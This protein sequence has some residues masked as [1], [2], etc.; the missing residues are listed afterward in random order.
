MSFLEIES[1]QKDYPDFSLEMGLS[2]EQGEIVVILGPSGG[3]KTTFL[4]IIAGLIAPDRGRIFLEGKDI[5]GLPP[6]QRGVGMVFQDFALFPHYDV[7]GNIAYGPKAHYPRSE[8][9][10]LAAQVE[11]LLERFSLPG[12]GP[13]RIQGLS[14]G[15]RQRVALARALAIN[16]GLMLFDEPLGSLDATLRK[17]L[18]GELRMLQREMGYTSISVTHDQEDALAVADRIVVV[19]DGRVVQTGTPEEVYAR[20][21]TAFVATFFGDANLIPMPD[22]LRFIRAEQIALASENPSTANLSLDIT[23]SDIE[24]RG[25]DYLVKGQSNLG[26]DPL[27]LCFRMAHRPRVGD[28]VRIAFPESSLLPIMDDREI[29]KGV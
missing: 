25:R 22:G 21:K 15:E 5:T 24:Y 13:R 23:V 12:F 19:R 2:C 11:K 29:I 7:A 28:S 9:K 27:Q 16:P 3:G 26:K 20:P 18:R 14:G 17:E 4:R 10:Q 1:I 8:P 6:R